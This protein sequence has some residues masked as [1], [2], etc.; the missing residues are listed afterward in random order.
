MTTQ[1][2]PKNSNI[3]ENFFRTSSK[4]AL[5]GAYLAGGLTLI[6]G[7]VCCSVY[8]FQKSVQFYTTP[9]SE[10]AQ[11]SFFNNIPGFGEASPH[12]TRGFKAC[13][14]F[15]D[16]LNLSSGPEV[17]TDL[18]TKN[19]KEISSPETIVAA[20]GTTI[21]GN[22]AIFV[23]SSYA[24]MSGASLIGKSFNSFTDALSFL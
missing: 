14:S 9:V 5:S 22:G 4:L 21:I 12:S 3:A 20:I 13:I 7:G 11:D 17:C 23:L 19:W 8:S 15:T 1:I 2:A 10:R 16:W 18:S 6:A 24:I